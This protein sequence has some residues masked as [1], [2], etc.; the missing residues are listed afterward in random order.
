MD[1]NGKLRKDFPSHGS[2]LLILLFNKSLSPKQ[3]CV[4]SSLSEFSLEKYTMTSL[5]KSI[6]KKTCV[7]K[8]TVRRVLQNLRNLGLIECG[9]QE[10]KGKKVRITKA[11]KE[12]LSYKRGYGEKGSHEAPDLELRVQFPLTPSFI[13]KKQLMK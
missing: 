13:F 10:N 4:V 11:G 1:R 12:I 5:V 9:D 2:N 8:P 6:A 7:S 3:R